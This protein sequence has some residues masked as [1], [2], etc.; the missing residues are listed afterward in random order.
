MAG[1][2]NKKATLK[3][4]CKEYELSIKKSLELQGIHYHAKALELDAMKTRG[5]IIYY[6]YDAIA[7][8]KNN[9]FEFIN[10]EFCMLHGLPIL[11]WLHGD[12]SDAQALFISL[13][14]SELYPDIDELLEKQPNTAMLLLPALARDKL[15]K[16]RAAIKEGS[17]DKAE[18]L[19]EEVRC[20]AEMIVTA[21]RYLNPAP[22]K[23]L[24]EEKQKHKK[25]ISDMRSELVKKTDVYKLSQEF[26]SIVS[27]YA[28]KVKLLLESKKLPSEPEDIISTCVRGV[29]F[30]I[31]HCD[32]GTSRVIKSSEREF[33]MELS[34]L[35]SEF[36]DNCDGEYKDETSSVS[37]LDAYDFDS[38]IIS[39]NVPK[40]RR[41]LRRVILP[42]PEINYP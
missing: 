22:Y 9:A 25:N 7:D 11:D 29:S 30:S 23:S 21:D 4:Q 28:H 35:A 27:D 3:K 42:L 14:V 36:E 13:I 40:L 8:V 5:H 20:I 2:V 16:A 1:P 32:L 19:I 31:D 41:H 33:F 12:F 34:R 10:Y 18:L 26:Q 17:F 37:V 6:V 39:V 24:N 38:E 15:N